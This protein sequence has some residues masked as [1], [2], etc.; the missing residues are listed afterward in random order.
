MQTSVLRFD[1]FE[2][3]LNSYELR[4][5]GRLIKLEKLPME[6]LILLAEGQG[7]LVSREQ[8]IQ[9]LWGDNIFVDTRQGINTAVRK[10]RIALQDDSEHPRLIQTL[11]GRGY[12]L[13]AP[14]SGAEACG[15][16]K[17]IEPSDLPPAA[18]PIEIALP[19][20]VSPNKGWRS[21][22]AVAGAAVI[23]LAIASLAALLFVGRS[24]PRPASREWVQVTNF[25]DS[26]TQPVLSPD[27]H[28]VAFIRGPETF[29]T[30]G[31]I[32][33]KILPDGE[34]IRLTHDGLPKMAPAFSFDGSRIAF[35]ATDRN[36]GWNTWV[37]PVLGGE[38]KEQ[39]GRAHV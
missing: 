26:A 34:A 1:Q 35:T 10:L 6:L 38:S 18:S 11:P 8:I 25:P 33:V 7:Q 30:P 27:G 28:M 24:K 17:A 14:V 39:I 13:L 37:V 36:F 29:V 5:S 31:E 9:R 3:D 2:L 16:A 12:R 21:G 20:P 19:N 22:M 32:Y 15:S 23:L 4:K